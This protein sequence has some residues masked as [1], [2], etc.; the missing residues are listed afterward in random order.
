[1]CVRVCCVRDVCV[2]SKL[3]QMNLQWHSQLI[4]K[5]IW[6]RVLHDAV[7]D[8]S[9][10]DDH[11]S[12]TRQCARESENNIEITETADGEYVIWRGSLPN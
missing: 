1:M 12:C 6:V 5:I 9:S 10:I 4:G 2:F 7:S 3:L 11:I 8:L